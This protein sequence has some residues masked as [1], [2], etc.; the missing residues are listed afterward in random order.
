MR[1]PAALWLTEDFSYS[2]INNPQ[3]VES[4][5]VHD[6]E[7][8]QIASKSTS[9]RS[10][11]S[12]G[13]LATNDER[14]PWE[15]PPPPSL[16]RPANC[17]RSLLTRGLFVSPV[18]M[19]QAGTA[20]LAAQ[21]QP[22]YGL[23]FTGTHLTVILFYMALSTGVIVILIYYFWTGQTRNT[24]LPCVCSMW[25]KV[26]TAVLGVLMLVMLIISGLE[27]RRSPCGIYTTMRPQYDQLG[28]AGK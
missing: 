9:Y 28:C 25:Y 4:N 6:M 15:Q 17:W 16:F 14:L 12:I 8:E 2:D 18:I 1:L 24:V 5:S 23:F 21:S 10:L 3:R 11:S 19:A 13:L 20:A 27:T 26:Y 7:L 22:G